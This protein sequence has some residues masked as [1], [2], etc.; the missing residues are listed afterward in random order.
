[1]YKFMIILNLQPGTRDRILEAAPAVQHATRD[2]PGCLAYDS[3]T[4]TDD[5]DKLVFVECFTSQE[6][7]ERHCEQPYTR[8]FIAFHEPFHQPLKLELVEVAES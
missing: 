4:C 1:M 6:A 2:E 7:H 5:P 3:F 8:E